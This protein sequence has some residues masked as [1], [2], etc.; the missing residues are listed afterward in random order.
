MRE[1][2]DSDFRPESEAPCHSKE[3][4]CLFIDAALQGSRRGRRA[5]DGKQSLPAAPRALLSGHGCS[6]LCTY[7]LLR[8]VG[9]D[10]GN[11]AG[12]LVVVNH[13]EAKCSS[14][15]SVSWV[16]NVKCCISLM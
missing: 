6:D 5:E 7:F 13:L 11:T 14:D 9:C 2:A 12:L 10:L 3:R 4:D 15:T 8:P 16:A 1:E